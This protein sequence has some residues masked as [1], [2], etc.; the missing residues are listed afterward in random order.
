M[1]LAYY[2]VFDFD[3]DTNQ[4]KYNELM[5][6]F[7]KLTEGYLAVVTNIN[8]GKA[9]IGYGYTFE[10]S[11]NVAQWKAANIWDSLSQGQKDKL[12][13]IDAASTASQKHQ[14]PMTFDYS[15]SKE[16]ATRLIPALLPQYEGPANSLGMIT[17]YEKAAFVSITYNR[18]VAVVN[19]TM[20]AFK[21][22]RKS[23]V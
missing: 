16:E 2:N 12:I 3:P 10:R 21:A 9:T 13:A 18:G 8:D 4:Q 14:I 11:D 7:V 6:K 1:S 15:P 20:Q 19:S 23:V 5:E 17:S 22:D